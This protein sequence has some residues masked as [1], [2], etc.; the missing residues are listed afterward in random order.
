M[1]NPR[2]VVMSDFH[3]IGTAACGIEF[4]SIPSPPDL[5]VINED[6]REV[7]EIMA[8]RAASRLIVRL[9]NS[10]VVFLQHLAGNVIGG[11]PIDSADV[12]R[13]IS[14]ADVGTEI[15]ETEEQVR[16][17]LIVFVTSLEEAESDMPVI[18]LQDVK[19]EELQM[20]ELE[21][22][23]LGPEH[24]LARILDLAISTRSNK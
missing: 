10:D 11:G 7:K 24:P 20:S 16:K 15:G 19:A 3:T 6:E 14:F 2:I 22:W 9:G 13:Q 18:R 8:V 5:N 1:V 4:I 12:L 21:I 17:R 23:G